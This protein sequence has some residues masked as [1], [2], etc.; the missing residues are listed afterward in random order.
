MASDIPSPLGPPRQPTP[1][2][3]ARVFE[4]IV[5]EET[6][7]PASWAEHPH[8]VTARELR[9]LC[10]SANCFGTLGRGC[11]DCLPQSGRL[12]GDASG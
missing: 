11:E 5:G 8:L 12:A 10:E 4:R 3:L 7:C 9:R 2:Q 6:G 1:A